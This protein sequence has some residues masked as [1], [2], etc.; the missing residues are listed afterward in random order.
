MD[1]AAKKS[2]V[3]QTNSFFASETT[4]AEREAFNDRIS[5]SDTFR[6][7]T[8]S[9]D[10]RRSEIFTAVPINIHV[11]V[12]SLLNRDVTR[13]HKT[14]EVFAARQHGVDL[15]R[16]DLA[17]RCHSTDVKVGVFNWKE[18][19]RSERIESA[20]RDQ[21]TSAILLPLDMLERGKIP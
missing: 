15:I 6:Y 9:T 5:H 20:R 18:E 19:S 8:E 14:H 1:L 3:I 4:Q 13:F 21:S 2:G 17:S 7:G 12:L 16:R 10:S 11:K